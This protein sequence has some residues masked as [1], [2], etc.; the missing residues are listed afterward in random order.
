MV[1]GIGFLDK[2]IIK[3]VSHEYTI[4]DPGHCEFD[5]TDELA[6][7]DFS[8]NHKIDVVIRSVVK[9]RDRNSSDINETSPAKCRK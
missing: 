6:V 3:A 5:L 4:I 8:R 7:R 1:R 2:P 9:H